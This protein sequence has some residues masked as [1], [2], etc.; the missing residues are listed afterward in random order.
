MAGGD[1]GDRRPGYSLHWQW[2]RSISASSYAIHLAI[3]L[4][5]STV[6]SPGLYVDVLSRT[7]AEA[8][9]RRFLQPVAYRPT[10]YSARLVAGGGESVA[11]E[12]RYLEGKMSQSQQNPKH[13]NF[14]YRIGSLSLLLILML[15]SFGA[16]PLSTVAATPG[17]GKDYIS[18]AS[19]LAP[20]GDVV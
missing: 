15:F 12:V 11:V 5:R 13:A 3:V 18:L 14:I 19:P 6:R 9:A 2:S 16:S 17:Q 20:G 7:N 8:V 10:A 4:E 1:A